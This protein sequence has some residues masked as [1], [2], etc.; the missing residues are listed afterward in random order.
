MTQKIAQSNKFRK[1]VPETIMALQ[2]ANNSNAQLLKA[3]NQ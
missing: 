1:G 3:E 2:N